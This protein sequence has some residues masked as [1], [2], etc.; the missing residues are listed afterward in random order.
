[1]RGKFS[2]VLSWVS[3][4]ILWL[5]FANNTGIRE[6]LIGGAAS[7]IATFAV[8]RF[9]RH[10]GARE[11]YRLR[12]PYLLQFF[13]VPKTVVTGTWALL[14]VTALRLLGRSVPGG[15]VS[16]PYRI[17]AENSISRGRRALTITFL[18]LGPK[19]LVLGFPPD[20]R[21]FF[22]HTLIPQ[23]LPPFM[24]KMGALP[25]RRGRAQ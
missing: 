25:G 11:H 18:T 15:I 7:A 5:A 4:W 6:I 13:R 21:S 14:R 10:T 2:F 3:Q 16:V 8:A 24:F 22:F 1:M 20:Q 19:S 17:G 12:A 23:P 9:Q